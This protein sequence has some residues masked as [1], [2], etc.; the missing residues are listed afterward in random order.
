MIHEGNSEESQVKRQ[1]ARGATATRSVETEARE[2]ALIK[3][4][5][6]MRPCDIE[7]VN[8]V[9]PDYCGFVV[10]FP[11]SR[12]SLT[13][14]QIIELTGLL[15]DQV[16]AVGVFVDQEPGFIA[17]LVRDSGLETVQLHG[18]ED[19]R[20]IAELREL[21]DAP[22][23]KAFKVRAPEDVAAANAS[24]ADYVLLDNGYGTG[25]TFDWS[26]LERV[27]RP[28]FLAGG[29]TPGNI[30]D[31]I[32]R[33]HPYAMDISSGIET[34]GVKDPAKMRAAVDAARG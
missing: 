21:T 13:P 34:D 22:V 27:E 6:M 2:C 29:L 18:H 23:I 14:E 15:S 16:E 30:P 20:Y 33:F 10:N 28:F 25:R 26:L 9:L 4:C 8:E 1:L 17:K 11:H 12:R 7:A 3:L 32:E 24:S 19:E 31:A 5:G